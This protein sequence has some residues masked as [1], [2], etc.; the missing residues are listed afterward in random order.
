MQ[1]VSHGTTPPSQEQIHE[2]KR[3][4]KHRAALPATR[5][6]FQTSVS[7]APQ[8]LRQLIPHE[9][10]R[11]AKCDWSAEGVLWCKN[12]SRR[13]SVKIYP[14]FILRREM[15]FAIPRQ[16]VSCFSAYPARASLDG[17]PVSPAKIYR[18]MENQRPW[19]GT[20]LLHLGRTSTN[21]RC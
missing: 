1:V 20:I 15:N 14:S 5:E 7:V 19:I 12:T 21:A 16:R 8:R 4:G 10:E 11:D 13:R 6:G 2:D 3:K 18:D 9:H 17:F